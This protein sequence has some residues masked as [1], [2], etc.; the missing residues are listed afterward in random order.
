[1]VVS[2]DNVLDTES[3]VAQERRAL[4][5]R[6]LRRCRI[7]QRPCPLAVRQYSLQGFGVSPANAREVQMRRRLVEQ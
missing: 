4:P 3:H 2:R 6:G 1:M 7:A 5:V